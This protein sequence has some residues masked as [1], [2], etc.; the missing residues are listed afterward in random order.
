MLPADPP[1]Y[2]IA[3]VDNA[4]HVLTL[5]K[6]HNTVR[7][8]EVS[9][10][11]GIARSSAHR[12]LSMLT[13]RGYARQDPTTKAYGPGPALVELGLAIV[14]NMD[15]RRT[16]RPYMERLS[17]E[18]GE[19]ICLMLLDPPK[20]LF[21]DSI[22]GP[23]SVRVASRTGRTMPAHCTSAGKAMLAALPPERLREIYADGRLETMTDRSIA[24]LEDL[25]AEIASIRRAGY[26]TNF[27]ESE[28]DISAVGVAII[29]T[30]GEP[31]AGFS[32]AAPASRLDRSRVTGIAA[33]L[34]HA[35]AE[36]GADA[37]AT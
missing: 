7:I 15:I 29:G 17:R 2:P 12:L 9:R 11:L 27:A 35:A 13:Y 20:V 31:I 24:T 34:Q 18:T 16:A 5:I 22:E 6:E 21:I 4:L 26:A 10:E 37:G 25:E 23:Q 3:A 28:A 14:R 19:T 36:I 1:A 30:A 33:A 32:A 8:A